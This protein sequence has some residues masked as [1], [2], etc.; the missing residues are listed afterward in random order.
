MTWCSL[1]SIAFANRLASA[2]VANPLF[3]LAFHEAPTGLK[4]TNQRLIGL[5]THGAASMDLDRESK[6]LLLFRRLEFARDQSLYVRHLHW[7]DRRRIERI[8]MTSQ[9]AALSAG[10][11]I[12]RF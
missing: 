8:R 4:E 7:I 10:S 2:S 11:W 5:A 1:E 9:P 3:C 6:R 12:S